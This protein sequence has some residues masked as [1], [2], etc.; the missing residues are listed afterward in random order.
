MEHCT[1]EVVKK[2]DMVEWLGKNGCERQTDGNGWVGLARPT[3][4]LAVQLSKDVAEGRVRVAIPLV[5]RF[6]VPV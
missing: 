4:I 6:V 5:V 1:L 3:I 2:K